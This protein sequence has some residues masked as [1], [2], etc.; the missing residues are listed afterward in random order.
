M[1]SLS[2][3][4]ERD[5][6]LIGSERSSGGTS[7]RSFVRRASVVTVLSLSFARVIANWK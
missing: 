5:S 6:R 2:R 3:L 7:K 1:R 4:S